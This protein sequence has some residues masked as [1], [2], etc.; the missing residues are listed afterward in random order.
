[1]C[2]L[3]GFWQLGG[4]ADP[5]AQS[6][7][8]QMAGTLTHRGPDDAGEW[9]DGR[10]GVALGHRRL[11]ILDPSPAG[12]QPMVSAN[13]R[14]VIVYNGEVYN[15]AELRTELEQ[16]G[17]TFRGHSDTEVLLEAINQ[18]GLKRA[19]RRVNGMFAFALWDRAERTLS[20]ARDRF[21]EKPLYYGWVGQTFV[22]ASEL[23]AIRA[24]PAFKAEVNRAALAL[25]LRLGYIPAPYSIFQGLNKLLPGTVLTVREADRG[26]ERAP[27]PYWS[28]EEVIAQ[29]LHDPFR[30]REVEAVAMLD[31]L[32]RAAIQ[33]RMVADV[34]V[35]A[36]LS[37]GIDSSTV[38]ALMQAQSERPVKTFT[39][40]FQEADYDEATHARAIARYLGTDHT[41]LSVTPAQAQAVILRLPT[42]YDEPFADASQIPT[43]LVAQV[44][45]TQVTV[46]LSGDGGDELFG[47]YNGYCWIPRIWKGVATL[48]LPLRRAFAFLLTRPSPKAWNL[49]FKSAKP[50]LPKRYAVPLAG[51]KVHKLADLLLLDSPESMYDLL[52]SLWKL[53]AEDVLRS[54]T[55]AETILDQPLSWPP[56]RSPE[57]RMMYLDQKTYL[58]DDVLVKVDRAAMGV[59]LESRMPFLDPAL[60]AF[61]WRLPLAMKIRHGQG[62]WLLRQVLKQYLPSS[63]IDRPKMGFGIP[64]DTWLR[65]P[66]RDWGEALLDKRRL[67]LGGLFDP[68][69]IRAKWAEHLSGRRNW[70]SALWC[71]LMFEA[72]RESQLCQAPAQV[73]V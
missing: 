69:P 36:F 62:K 33:L 2:G 14:Y 21:G 72:W 27:I 30:G 9:V 3:T 18:W 1:M 61:A 49:V 45:R 7:V 60:V 20:L 35:G 52:V 10:V 44:A 4:F 31:G 66:L 12:R 55:C 59:S 25:F 50:F 54:A 58:P 6:L 68:Q 43:Y 46:S 39:I 28:L 17:V 56:L 34:P 24:Y 70:Q 42:L 64:L 53:Q 8:R 47:G 16:A 15:F 71:V 38:V 19:L 37:G 73:H 67:A 32:L 65:G 40:G 51:D 5:E 48:P 29:G 41:E 13:G 57:E 63:L 11:A 22:F 26:C 23:K